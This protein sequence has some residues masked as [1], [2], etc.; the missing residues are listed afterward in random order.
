MDQLQAALNGTMRLTED[1]LLD[2]DWN[3]R[4]SNPTYERVRATG[5]QI[6][7]VLD[8]TF[9]DNPLWYVGRVVTVHPLWRVPDGS[10]R[11]RGRRRLLRAGLR[12]PRVRH[13]RRFGA[14]GANR[15]KPVEHD[16]R[17]RAPV[18]RAPDR[19]DLSLEG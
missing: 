2:V 9:K 3:K 14:A 4:G 18:C 5:R 6:A 17:A 19:R 10:N 12:L 11:A 15:T 8:G 16:L 13:R 1:G 7:D